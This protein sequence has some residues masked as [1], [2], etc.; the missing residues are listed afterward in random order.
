M[1]SPVKA[2]PPSINGWNA[3]YLEAQYQQF[4]QDASSVPAD[5][6]AFFQGFDLAR[7]ASVPAAGVGRPVVAVSS[8]ASAGDLR[9]ALRLAAGTLGLIDAYRRFGHFAAKLDVFDRP[10]SRPASLELA[11]HGL[12]DADLDKAVAAGTL[13]VNPGSTLRQVRDRLEQTYCGTIGAQYMH[14]ADDAQREWLRQKCESNSGRPALTRDEKVQVLECVIKSEQFERFLQKR[15]PG[16]KRF[17]LEGGESLIP[18]LERVIRAAGESKVEEIVIGMP[19]RG[20]LNV[21]N[22]VL[23]KTYEQI[24][25]EFEDNFDEDFADGGG[26]VKYHRGYSGERK[27]P[28]GRS[29][30]L[31]VASNP[32][33]LESVN[34]VVAGRCRAKQRLRNDSERKRVIPITIHGDAGIIGQG[35][36]FE[37]LNFAQLEGY[38]CGGTIHAVINNMIGFT[39]IPEDSR[40][41]PYCTDGA[42]MIDAPVFHV[43]G[44]DPEAVVAVAQIAL[45]YR[46]T[47]KRDVF[48][49]LWC[50]RK[51]G[52]NEQ[53]EQSF[54][55]PILAELIRNKRSVV[56]IYT[57]KLVRDGVLSQ[58]AMDEFLKSV[59]GRLEAAQK[60][61]KETPHDPTIDPA[62]KRWQGMG[63]DFSFDP[64]KTAVTRKQIE[65]VC[66]V[67]AKIPAGFD[68]NPKLKKLM[69]DRATLLETG[70]ITYADAEMLAIGTLLAEGTPVRIS[71]QDSRR[72]TFSHRHA[73]LRDFKTGE[74]YMPLN[75]MRPISALPDDAG[76]PGP[77]GK[78]TQA[79]LCVYDSPLSE[80]SV[81]GFDYGY[82][83]ADPNMLVMWEAQFGDFNNGA[84]IMIDQY[85]ASAEIKWDRWSG[86]TLLLPHGYEGAG[87]EHSSCRLERFLLLCADDNMQVVYPTTGAQLFHLLRRQVSKQRKFRKPLVIATPKSYL[88]VVTSHINELMEGTFRELLDD[89]YFEK[90]RDGQK[91]DRKQV[92][93]VMLCSGKFYHELAERRDAIKRYDTALVRI[94]QLY[95]F[96][97]GM[98]KEILAKYPAKAELVF[99]QEEPRNAGSFLFV[100]DVMRQAGMP[101]AKYI[102]RKASAT[103]ATG[104]KHKHKEEQEALLTEAMGPG[105]VKVDAHA[106][107][108]PVATAATGAATVGGSKKSK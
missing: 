43:N 64:V 8:S 31:S 45:E 77:D 28:G 21:L 60:A 67:N 105:P 17:S 32:S 59:D 1:S 108:A 25:T 72:G 90:G 97:A 101:I 9:E 46:Q 22:N 80:Y 30:S 3:E 34:A 2:V 81:M 15:Y 63:W 104:S 84:Q 74:P 96:H 20:R 55:Q 52:H 38:T 85:L 27:L 4:L 5:L 89:P 61:A 93:R 24:F 37:V 106:H 88:R 6:Q 75:N 78:P 87:P 36:N 69:A 33:H 79:K 94:E 100:D 35:V 57:E 102:G 86:L 10:R 18:L 66:A 7:S 51:Y 39:T 11:A 29:M 48:I 42:L 82:S 41:S 98:A 95:P 40:S 99:A 47:F 107:A 56:T 70:A 62:G 92:R 65:E 16:D 73:V 50:F 14:I 44:D 58:G 26:D 103:P 23:G 13:P 68:V 49:D 83:L 76:K 91:G 71:G 54:T 19:H 12:S 53:D